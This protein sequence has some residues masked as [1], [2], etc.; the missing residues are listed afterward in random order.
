VTKP[1]DAARGFTRR[2]LLRGG[3]AGSAL[4]ALGGVGLAL[5]S[6]RR[7]TPPAEALRVLTEDEH[8]ILAAVAARV[9]PQPGPDVPGAEALGIALAAD[10]L[11][12]L[13]GPEA[14]SGVKS[15]LGL[16]E[17]G[18]AGA[19]FFEHARPFTQ[20]APEDQDAVLLAWRDS[21]VALRRTVFRA[22]SALVA[23]LYYCDP[24]TWPGIGYP[25]PPDRHALRSA[26]AENLVD[27]RAL[28]AP[29][30]EP[31]GEEAS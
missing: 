29:G 16:F 1:I 21:S 5:Q 26:Y 22:L 23:S 17:S 11:F 28:A 25:G 6:T 15:A 9:C 14:T 10:R 7:G 19:I 13:A 24:R 12:E 20:L 3:L 18:L 30:D 31:W 2:N 27:Q 8:A 4:L